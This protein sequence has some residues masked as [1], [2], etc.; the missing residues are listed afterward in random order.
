MEHCPTCGGPVEIGGGKSNYAT[1]YYRPIEDMVVEV[2]ATI[3]DY[4]YNHTR[5]DLNTPAYAVEYVCQ[6]LDPA[7]NLSALVSARLKEIRS[8]GA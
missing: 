7:G 8:A 1:K 2:L 6:E 3:K 5:T 4:Q